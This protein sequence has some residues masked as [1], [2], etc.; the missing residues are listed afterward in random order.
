MCTEQIHLLELHFPFLQGNTSR[1]K[2]GRL[3]KRRMQWNDQDHQALLGSVLMPGEATNGF[4]LADFFYIFFWIILDIPG[5][6]MC[7]SYR[8]L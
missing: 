4:F 3:Q 8:L 5:R 7:N 2:Q 6:Y 1:T